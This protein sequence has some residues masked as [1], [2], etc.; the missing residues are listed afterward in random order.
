MVFLFGYILGVPSGVVNG[1]TLITLAILGVLL[2]LEAFYFSYYFPSKSDGTIAYSVSVQ[3]AILLVRGSRG[4]VAKNLVEDFVRSDIGKWVCARCGISDQALLKEVSEKSIKVSLADIALD[5]VKGV[6][7]LDVYLGILFD[8]KPEFLH[9][10]LS[11]GVNR[12][13]ILEAALWYE[14]R[15]VEIIHHERWW[16]VETLARVP[17]IGKDWAYGKTFKLDQYGTELRDIVRG[18]NF[19]LNYGNKEADAIERILVRAREANALLVGDKAA[20]AMDVVYRLARQIQEGTIFPELEHKRVVS[21]DTRELIA[22]T[23]EKNAFEQE[24]ILLMNEAAHAGNIILFV[25]D[26]PDFIQNAQSIGSDI[27]PLLNPYFVS[28]QVQMLAISDARRYH[29]LIESNAD[30]A[31]HFEKVLLES[32]EGDGLFRLVESLVTEAETENPKIFF[33]VQAVREIA[34]SAERY[35]SESSGV[36]R[37]KDLVVELIPYVRNLKRTIVTGQDVLQLVEEKTGIPLGEI[38]TAEK[39]T[40]LNLETFLAGRI[41]GQQE[42]V[43][44]IS[45]AMRRSRSGVGNPNRPTG[46][47]LF[48]GPTGVGKTETTKALAQCF[49]GSETSM[50]RFDMSEYR[51]A[52]AM[53]RLIGSFENGKTGVLVS[54]LREQQ[55][56]VLLLDEFEKTLHEVHDLFLQILD[57]GFFSDVQGK[58]VNVRNSIIIATSNAGSQLIWEAVQAGKNLEDEKPKIIDYIVDQGLFKPELL[59]RFDGIILFHPLSRDELSKIAGLMLKKVAKRLEE[60]GIRLAFDQSVI[61]YLVDSGMDPKFGA[62]AMNRVIQEKVE[63][64]IATKIIKGELASGSTHTLT[65]TDLGV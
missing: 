18:R 1:L 56:G 6:I 35:F 58:K 24:L 25:D 8:T 27:V 9:A 61:S 51:T 47:F 16:S 52:D 46:S 45:N 21:L 12:I 30:L 64:G 32:P 3:T 28:D 26:L 44:A 63:Q 14:R 23:K 10:V 43:K 49:F 36:D 62:R 20:G 34:K 59:N 55:Y 38:T 5:S 13:D 60:K 40:L 33:T 19:F 37:V 54:K 65:V 53:E 17:G 39:D 11:L 41:I 15:Q 50:T 22:F 31:R 7:S 2:A 48:L 42:A 57:E 29:E 4:V